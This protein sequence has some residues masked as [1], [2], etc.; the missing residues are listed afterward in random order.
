MKIRSLILSAFI[1]GTA[2]G[3]REDLCEKDFKEDSCQ[4]YP[5]ETCLNLCLRSG[6]PPPSGLDELQVSFDSGALARGVPN[7]RTDDRTPVKEGGR[8]CSPDS[9]RL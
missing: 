5:N 1:F 7:G 4:K 2:A 9:G 3:C 8:V 6:S